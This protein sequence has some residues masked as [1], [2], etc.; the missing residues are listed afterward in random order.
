MT[1]GLNKSS[2]GSQIMMAFTWVASAVLRMA[3]RFPGF[4][5][6]SRIKN[7]G[8]VVSRGL[9]LVARNKLS[10]SWVFG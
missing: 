1:L 9:I 3:P 4:S 5:G 8:T 10:G 7:S 6:D 2:L